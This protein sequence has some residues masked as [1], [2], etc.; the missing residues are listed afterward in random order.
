MLYSIGATNKTVPPVSREL[1]TPFHSSTYRQP[2]NSWLNS[3]PNPYERFVKS[4]ATGIVDF[5]ASTQKVQTAANGLL[6]KSTSSLQA[7]EALSSDNKAVSASA[8]NEA[9]IGNYKIKIQ[10]I[11]GSQINSGTELSKGSQTAI[12]NGENRFK[13]TIGGKSTTISSHIAATDTNEQALTKLKNA[14]NEAKTGITANVVND[15]ETGKS[16]L[17][18]SSDKTG[19]DQAFEVTDESGNAA[20]SSGIASVTSAATNAIY[21]VNGGAAQTSQSNV[22]ELE[23]GKVTATLLKPTTSEEIEITVRPDEKK[24]L[25]QVGALISGYNAMRDSLKEAS[26]YMSPAIARSLGD[27]VSSASYERIGIKKNADGSLKLD[28]AA[29]TKSLNANFEQ[30]SK[31]ISGIGGLARSLDKATDRFNDAS[32]SSLLNKQ[33]QIMQQ[34]A[35]YQSTMQSY[36]PFPTTGLLVNGFM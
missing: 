10:S 28:E 31:T 33:M 5:L 24:A 1:Y 35:T 32:A 25:E 11:A 16:K 26:G 13:L 8:R 19:T 20:A 34:Y 14:I 7:R 36:L 12:Q 6:N 17:V 2:A 27:A 30:T 23:K 21:T 9:L 29:F 3:Y 15:S 22:I 4:A 18:L